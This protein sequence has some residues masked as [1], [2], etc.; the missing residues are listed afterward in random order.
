[1]G[2]DTNVASRRCRGRSARREEVSAIL[3]TVVDDALSGTGRTMNVYDPSVRRPLAFMLA[4]QVWVVGCL[5]T[6]N[7]RATVPPAAVLLLNEGPIP[8]NGVLHF[9]TSVRSPRSR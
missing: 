5:T 8:A 6:T 2:E 1:M 4:A 3:C 7:A 9:S